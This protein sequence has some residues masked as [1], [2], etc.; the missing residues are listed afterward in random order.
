MRGDSL[1][2][3]ELAK[4]LTLGCVNSKDLR[5]QTKAGNGQMAKAIHLITG[6]LERQTMQLEEKML[7]R[8]LQ[9]VIGM[10]LL[11]A[12]QLRMRLNLG[13]GLMFAKLVNTPQFKQQ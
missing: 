6:L 4:N 13:N 9:Q 7:H 12:V 2:L 8:Y 3:A 11:L 1:R 10:M 5:N